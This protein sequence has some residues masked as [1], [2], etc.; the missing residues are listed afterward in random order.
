M[1]LKGNYKAMVPNVNVR[2]NISHEQESN[3]V[4]GPVELLFKTIAS[5][6]IQFLISQI[7]MVP[8]S[9]GAITEYRSVG[10]CSLLLLSVI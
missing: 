1:R 9:E 4:G 3:L 8:A 2:L 10:R 5:K 7:I 6:N